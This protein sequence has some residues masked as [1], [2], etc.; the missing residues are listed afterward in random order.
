MRKKNLV[1]TCF[2]SASV[3]QRVTQ[4]CLVTFLHSGRSFV[5][6]MVF[7]PW[8]HPCSMNFFAVSFVSVN[9]CGSCP[10][11]HSL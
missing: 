3:S 5:W 8:V 1:E 6:G 9:C 4:F 7:L 10:D 11:L 2:P